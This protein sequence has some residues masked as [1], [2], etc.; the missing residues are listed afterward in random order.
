MTMMRIPGFWRLARARDA[1]LERTGYDRRNWLRIKQIEAFEAALSAVSANASVLEVSPGWNSHWRTV[2]RGP[3]R[4][5]DF[6][7]FDVCQH[8]LEERFDVVIADQVLEHVPR[9]REAAANL[10][11]MVKPG[12]VAL[13]ATPFLF[14]IHARPHDYSRWTAD[15][16]RELLIEAGFCPERTAVSQWGNKACARAHIGGPVR[17][18]GYGRDLSNDPEYPLMVWAVAVRPA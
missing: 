1:F 9:P 11:A 4:S 10:F 2:A 14:R 8:K 15:G 13:V 5:V 7:E 18:Y 16:L 12:G 3:Y 17:D 6:P